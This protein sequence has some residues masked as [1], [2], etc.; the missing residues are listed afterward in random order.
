MYCYYCCCRGR[1]G[2][3]ELFDDRGHGQS[4]RL[5]LT[6]P[7]RLAIRQQRRR[8][9]SMQVSHSLLLYHTHTHAIGH[10]YLISRMYLLLL[11]IKRIRSIQ[12]CVKRLFSLTV[13][14]RSLFNAAFQARIYS[15]MFQNAE[16]GGEGSLN[17][18]AAPGVV[19]Q[20]KRLR[21]FHLFRAVVPNF[22]PSPYK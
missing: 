2:V 15:T 10:A 22:F 5:F 9:C 6:F 12:I 20:T 18:K 8:C 1:S 11:E 21:A 16:R 19:M 7:R 4:S 17:N 14:R 3:P 13:F